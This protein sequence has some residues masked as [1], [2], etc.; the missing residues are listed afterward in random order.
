MHVSAGPAPYSGGGVLSPERRIMPTRERGDSFRTLSQRLLLHTF[1]PTRFSPRHRRLSPKGHARS[2]TLTHPRSRIHQ[3]QYIT[4]PTLPHSPT[5]HIHQPTTFTNLPHS[6][7]LSLY[8]SIPSSPP[9]LTLIL[10]LTATVE[11]T[12]RNTGC[13]SEFIRARVQHGLRNRDEGGA[14]SPS[15]DLFGSL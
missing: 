3:L 9:S 4:L 2:L 1:V 6:P 5:Y 13:G 7:T 8:R 12:T 14:C 10:I 15:R 11:L